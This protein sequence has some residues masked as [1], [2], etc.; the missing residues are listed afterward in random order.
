MSDRAMLEVQTYGAEPGHNGRLGRAEPPRPRTD[1]AEV[2]RSRLQS[3]PTR[4]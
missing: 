1:L 4:T 3:T 2:A